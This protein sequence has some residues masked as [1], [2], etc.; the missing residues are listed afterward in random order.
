MAPK[1]K[2]KMIPVMMIMI[3]NAHNAQKK[4]RSLTIHSYG[5][6]NLHFEKNSRKM[7]SFKNHLLEKKLLISK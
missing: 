4:E 3:Y 7:G 6:E 5:C 1:F 2:K